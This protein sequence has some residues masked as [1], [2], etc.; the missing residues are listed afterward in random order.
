MELDHLDIIMQKCDH[1]AGWQ[2]TKDDFFKDM[3]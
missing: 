2:N 1:P 3:L